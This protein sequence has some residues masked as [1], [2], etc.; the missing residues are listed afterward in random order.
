MGV[1]NPYSIYFMFAC[2][3]FVQQKFRNIYS[4]YKSSELH[5][6]LKLILQFLDEKKFLY[7]FSR[8]IVMNMLEIV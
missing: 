1:N 7:F 2:M 3:Q 8:I 4:V 6:M 5:N